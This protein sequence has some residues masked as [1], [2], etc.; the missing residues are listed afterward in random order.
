MA[1]YS[2]CDRS[3]DEIECLREIQALRRLNHHP[4]IIQLE[5]VIL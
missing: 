4:N 2:P 3:V 5:E 1:E